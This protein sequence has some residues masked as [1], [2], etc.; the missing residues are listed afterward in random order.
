[1]IEGVKMTREQADAEM[2]LF[3][4]IFEE[5]R[6]LSKEEIGSEGAGRTEEEMLST[7]CQ[8]K[9]C[10]GHVHNEAECIAAKVLKEKTQKT[11]LE[12]INS[13]LYEIVAR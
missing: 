6:L 5:V 9:S 4:K 10:A 7:I 12:Y 8:C 1:M 2:E 13:N 11:K 3:R